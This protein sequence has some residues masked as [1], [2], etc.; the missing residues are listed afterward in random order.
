MNSNTCTREADKNPMATFCSV[1]SHG[2]RILQDLRHDI[3]AFTT[4]FANSNFLFYGP[5]TNL[6]T[7]GFTLAW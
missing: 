1:I 4:K 5:P 7:G 2:R 3:E 6:Y